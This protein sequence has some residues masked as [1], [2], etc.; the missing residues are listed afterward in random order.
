MDKIEDTSASAIEVLQKRPD[1]TSEPRAA[2][3]GPLQSVRAS[4]NGDDGPEIGQEEEDVWEDAQEQLEDY[5]PTH[6]DGRKK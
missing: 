5:L 1:R 4:G 6:A 3:E 2:F